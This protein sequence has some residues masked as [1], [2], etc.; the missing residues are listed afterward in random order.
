MTQSYRLTITYEDA[1]EYR[2]TVAGYPAFVP[3]L[4]AADQL[5]LRPGEQVR[6]DAVPTDAPPMVR[7]TGTR[8]LAVGGWLRKRGGA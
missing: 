3:A 8:M 5:L 1:R 7:S 4:D 2:R 6:I